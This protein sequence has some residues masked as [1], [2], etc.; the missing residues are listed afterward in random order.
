MNKRVKKPS[1]VMC[2]LCYKHKATQAD[3]YQNMWL[4]DDC[5]SKLGTLS[6]DYQDNIDKA[7]EYVKKR[8]IASIL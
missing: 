4:C 5:Y 8:E 3:T 1:A 6:G 7:D 2:E